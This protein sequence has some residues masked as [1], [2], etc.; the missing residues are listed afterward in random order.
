MTPR[1]DHMIIKDG[2][3][4]YNGTTGMTWSHESMAVLDR[5][6]S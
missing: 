4:F 6:Q 2:A 5:V 3:I 1:I